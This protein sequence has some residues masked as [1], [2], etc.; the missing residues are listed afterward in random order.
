[1]IFR[2]RHKYILFTS[3]VSLVFICL[4]VGLLVLA[5]IM[6]SS[7]ETNRSMS[8]T[9][10]EWVVKNSGAR[11]KYDDPVRSAEFVE[12]RRKANEKPYYLANIAK[13]VVSIEEK[14][15]D[16]MQVFYMNKRKSL[17]KKNRII[18]D[19]A[20]TS[21]KIVLFLHGGGYVNEINPT[22]WTMLDALADKSGAQI[23]VP[24]YPLAP[25]H[26]Y[27][28]AYKRLL[29]IY[30]D[31]LEENKATDITLMGDSAGGGL[32]AGFCMYLAKLGID[33]PENLILLSPWLDL[34]MSNPAIEDYVD[35]D[36]LLSPYGLNVIA[37]SWA[38][39]TDLHYWMLSPIFGDV[40]K[41]QNVITYV[42]T[43]EIFFPDVTKFNN[44]LEAAGV[45][46]RIHIGQGLNHV[47]PVYPTKEARKAIAEMAE[48]IKGSDEN[49]KSDIIE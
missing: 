32:A 14:D 20:N 7:C 3:A 48:V 35:I 41:L 39:G 46:S 6:F 38:G 17:I 19:E 11:K 24:L 10:S 18:K 16:G 8:A 44:I 22:H 43:H 30:T 40:S 45:K 49:G 34:T 15:I 28:N 12:E 5:A 21:K 2:R 47:Y 4:F 27:W 25:N 42:G 26:K 36:P 13:L 23:I 9:V 1:M 33:Q 37:E 29:M 31:L